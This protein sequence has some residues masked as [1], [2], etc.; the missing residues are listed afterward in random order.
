MI[1][2]FLK[3]FSMEEVIERYRNHVKDVQTENSATVEDVQH[4][5]QETES[6]GNKIKVLELA[7][8]KLLGEGLGS[9]TVEELQDIEHQLE[10]SLRIIRARKMQ[11]Y[12]EQIHELRSKEKLLASQNAILNG[13]CLVHNKEEIEERRANFQTINREGSSDV[14]TRLFI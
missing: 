6:M 1:F 10:R 5:R 7:K 11:V 8:R 9:S 12:N 3:L 2:V 13:K 14:E 4:L